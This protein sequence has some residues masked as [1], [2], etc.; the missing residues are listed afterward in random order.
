MDNYPHANAYNI[1]TI[2]TMRF[3]ITKLL[4]GVLKVLAAAG[5]YDLISA[6]LANPEPEDIPRVPNRSASKQRPYA[7]RRR[8]NTSSAVNAILPARYRQ[9]QLMAQTL[10]CHLRKDIRHSGLRARNSVS[11]WLRAGRL[12]TIRMKSQQDL[13]N[14]GQ[15]LDAPFSGCYDRGDPYRHKEPLGNRSVRLTWWTRKTHAEACARKHL[16][17]HPFEDSTMLENHCCE[18]TVPPQGFFQILIRHGSDIAH[19]VARRSPAPPGI[20]VPGAN[21]DPSWSRSF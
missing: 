13:V 2:L 20:T 6:G 18:W 14:S 10:D 19:R 8:R 7:N 15:A 1:L 12:S 21:C 16:G 9:S 5:Y 11:Y 17:C 4:N 3:I